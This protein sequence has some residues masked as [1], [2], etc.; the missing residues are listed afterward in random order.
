MPEDLILDKKACEKIGL[1]SEAIYLIEY[2]LNS[3]LVIPKN[4]TANEKK[5][6][7]ERNKKAEHIRNLMKFALKFN[8]MATKHLE[9]AWL[10]AKER[11]PLAVEE[12]EKIKGE[13]RSAG[14][15]NVDKRI[16]IV[17]LMTTEAGFEDFQNMKTQFLLDFAMEHVKY[18]E[19]GLEEER[20]PKSSLWRCKKAYE[21]INTLADE[22]NSEDARN[23]VKDTVSLL[24]DKIQLVE[25]MILKQEEEEE[26]NK[27]K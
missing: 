27:V 23:E 22:L 9:S 17:P 14:F 13:M 26:K 10:I 16:R 25:A 7:E 12:L 4:A 19:K 15:D 18:C 1:H 11:L 8:I 3:Q 21:I 24:D 5:E 6:L 20:L 2:D